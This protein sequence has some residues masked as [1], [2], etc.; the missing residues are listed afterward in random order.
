MKRPRE[1]FSNYIYLLLFYGVL[2]L[3]G[4]LISWNWN[5]LEWYDIVSKIY[6]VIVLFFIVV[7]IESY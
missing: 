3:L 4:S 5:I 7:L 6:M 2:Y 1:I